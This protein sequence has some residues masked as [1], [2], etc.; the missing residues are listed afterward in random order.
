MEINISK[1]ASSCHRCSMFMLFAVA[2]VKSVLPLRCVW[3]LDIDGI[4]MED[5]NAGVL[6]GILDMPAIRL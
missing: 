5:E 3:S 2:F 4:V 1:I 6:H